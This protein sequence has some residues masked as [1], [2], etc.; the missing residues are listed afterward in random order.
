[1]ETDGVGGTKKTELDIYLSGGVVG[2]EENF[3]ILRWWKLN[4]ERFPILSRMARD[5]LAVPVSTVASESAFSTSGRVLDDFRSS[6]TPALVEALI[7]TQD[8]LKDPTQ[9]VSVEES[10]DE[11]EQFE[12]G[13]QE[14]A[15]ANTNEANPIV[16]LCLCLIYL[17][18]AFYDLLEACLLI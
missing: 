9:P 8:W 17:L 7:C 13:L 10:L 2:N 16:C 11:L 3:D 1:M 14:P 6:L 12:E 18:I 15:S 4:S 5:V